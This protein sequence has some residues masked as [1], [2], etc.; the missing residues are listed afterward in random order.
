L[1]AATAR[2]KVWVVFEAPAAFFESAE[3]ATAVF[4]DDLAIPF[5]VEADPDVDFVDVFFPAA[6]AGEVFSL[7]HA[8]KR[9]AS[10]SAQIEYRMT[11]SF[12]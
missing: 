4:P 5:A 1:G 12:F 3:E 9:K 2:V 6:G 7:G 8:D 11:A 10:P